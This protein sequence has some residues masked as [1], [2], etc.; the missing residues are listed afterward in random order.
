MVEC[1]SLENCLGGIPPYEGSNPSLSARRN[2][3][4]ARLEKRRAFV[5]PITARGY[6]GHLTWNDTDAET[7][8]V[9]SAVPPKRARIR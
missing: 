5:L 9:R 3:K 7:D 6:G 2:A 8:A 4:K 1:G